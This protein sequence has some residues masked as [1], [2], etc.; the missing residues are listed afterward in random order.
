MQK[1]FAKFSFFYYGRL[2]LPHP[3]GSGAVI[4]NRWQAFKE[5]YV[6]DQNR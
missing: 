1:I 5:S 3:T 4:S 2:A 6:Q